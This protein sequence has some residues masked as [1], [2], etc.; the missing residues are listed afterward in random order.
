MNEK[1]VVFGGS[2][3][4]GV[5]TARIL[6]SRGYSVTVCDIAPCKL[7]GIAGFIECDITNR[8][9]VNKSIKDA[10]I[11]YNFAGLSDLDQ[12]LAHPVETVSHNV[13]GNAHILEACLRSSVKRYMY[14]STVYVHGNKGGFYRCSKQACELY[15]EE[16]NSQ[17]G[18]EYT[19]M[20][21]GSLYGPGSDRR[22]GLYKIV[23]T[24]LTTRKI[25]YRGDYN[26][27]REY[28]HVSDAAKISVDLLQPAYACSVLSLVGG[29][30][31]KVKEVLEML[32]EILGNGYTLEEPL[33]TEGVPTYLGHYVTTPY[34]YSG[35][36]PLRYQS[37]CSVDFACGLLELIKNV[38]AD[39]KAR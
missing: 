6:I 39:L 10:S 23:E 35:N 9:K 5:E 36:Q 14:A 31:F 15:I 26:A 11:V 33:L 7:T 13:L 32:K 25:T 1:V 8:D 38:D 27:T 37:V 3:F 34:S 24:A 21:Y 20:R 28:I 12:G 17:W 30:R 18:L 22:N 29:A 16:Y 4:L 19:I 2:G